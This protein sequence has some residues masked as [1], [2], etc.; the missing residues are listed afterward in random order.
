[1]KQYTAITVSALCIETVRTYLTEEN[2]RYQH[3]LSICVAHLTAFGD[4]EFFMILGHLICY[5]STPSALFVY[6]NI[7]LEKENLVTA[8]CI[9]SLFREEIKENETNKEK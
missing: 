9:C 3:F 1:M 8:I 5:I 2:H 6:L 4:Y 7:L